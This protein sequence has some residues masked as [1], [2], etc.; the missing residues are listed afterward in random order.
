MW[1]LGDWKP[2][3]THK[4]WERVFM[5]KR[6]GSDCRSNAHYVSLESNVRLRGILLWKCLLQVVCWYNL[7]GRSGLQYRFF[8]YVRI[9]RADFMVPLN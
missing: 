5:D 9:I 3:R 4:R 1:L 2:Y 7:Y 6:M 8:N